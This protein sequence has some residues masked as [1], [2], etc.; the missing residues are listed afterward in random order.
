M[1]READL[2]AMREAKFAAAKRFVDLGWDKRAPIVTKSVT[3]KPVTK[4]TDEQMEKALVA[5]KKLG[6]PRKGDQPMS[7]AERV[8]A[9]RE[10]KRKA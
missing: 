5:L 2:R 6:R 1:T 9:Y 10:R 7:S 8:R 4:Y 3:K